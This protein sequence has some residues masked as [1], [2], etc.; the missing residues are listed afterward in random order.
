[1]TVSGEELEELLSSVITPILDKAEHAGKFPYVSGMRYTFEQTGS[2]VASDP[3][4][5]DVGEFTQL[6]INT[7]TIDAP[8]WVNIEAD[9]EYTIITDTY[10]ANG[11]DGWTKVAE[12]NENGELN[13]VDLAF[14]IDEL[15]GFPVKGMKFNSEKKKYYP[16][17]NE[18]EKLD[19]KA[20]EI[21]CD[22][23]SRA[24]INFANGTSDLKPF[25]AEMVTL[26]LLN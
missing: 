1:M 13:R 25:E 21:K 8:N 26:K 24:F 20:T 23:D 12:S 18:S 10:H 15:A 22:V 11:R 9:S 17:Y 14:V 2:K 4:S 19:C 7:A 3:N 5:K 6:Q 16:E